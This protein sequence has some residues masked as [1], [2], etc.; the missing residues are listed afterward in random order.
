MCT[1]PIIFRM[2]VH[3]CS[4]VEEILPTCVGYILPTH[5][6]NSQFSDVYVSSYTNLPTLGE[7]RT[8]WGKREQAPLN[9]YIAKALPVKYEITAHSPWHV[10][11]QDLSLYCLQKRLTA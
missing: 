6:K 5:S 1:L 9:C 4:F 10:A 7:C 3:T 8:L 11:K 2:Q